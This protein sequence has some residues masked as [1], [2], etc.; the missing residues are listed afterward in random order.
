[1]VVSTPPAVERCCV[2]KAFAPA[3][4]DAVAPGPPPPVSP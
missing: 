2:W 1:M 3:V 4:V